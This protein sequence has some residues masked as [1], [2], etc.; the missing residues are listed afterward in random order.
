MGNKQNSTTVVKS[1][2]ESENQTTQR[3]KI[4][5]KQS[6]NGTVDKNNFDFLYVIGRG[7]FGK[8]K[9]LIYFISKKNLQKF[10]KN[11]YFYHRSGKYFSKNIKNATL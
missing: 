10:S 11:L 3:Q 4:K 2:K 9:N 6:N 1:F 8:V 7:G 5:E